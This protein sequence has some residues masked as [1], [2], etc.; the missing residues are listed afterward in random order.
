MSL[1]IVGGSGVV[2]FLILVVLLAE[3]QPMLRI[4]SEAP[5]FTL[6][7]EGGGKVRL[8]DYRGKMIVV[9]FFYPKDFTAGCTAEVCGYRDWYKGLTRTDVALLGVSHDDA[10]SHQKFIAAHNLP[11]TLLSDS[12]H[13]VTRR[14]DALWLGG[15]VPFTR[16]VTYVID[17]SGIVRGAFHHEFAIGSFISDVANVLEA[18]KE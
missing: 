15:L 7:S 4:G 2:L 10:V 11:F 16:R 5:D 14:Y 1:K 9:L 18:L 6:G 17:K 8:R 12:D 13:S 3:C